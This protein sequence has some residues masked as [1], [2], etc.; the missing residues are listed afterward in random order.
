MQY[1]RCKCGN[2]EHWGSGMDPFPCSR[3]PECGSTAS[4]APA[5]HKEPAPH[6]F[7]TKYDVNTGEPYEACRTC[8]TRRDRLPV[9]EGGLKP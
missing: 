5:A 6:V 2:T 3:C 7:V 9:S 4:F 8:Y 1:S